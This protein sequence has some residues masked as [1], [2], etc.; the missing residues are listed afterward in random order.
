[1]M[2]PRGWGWMVT[3]KS[4]NTLVSF[5]GKM[6][7]F[8]TMRRDMGGNGRKV[9]RYKISNSRKVQSVDYG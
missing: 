7:G 4:V 1:M 6:T 3:P 2:R 9:K 8:R 5:L